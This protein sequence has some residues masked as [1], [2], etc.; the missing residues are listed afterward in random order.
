MGILLGPG[1][2]SSALPLPSSPGFTEYDAIQNIFSGQVGVNFETLE[3]VG[4]YC[5]GLPLSL[6]G[7]LQTLTF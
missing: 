1:A 7:H 5:T 4:H 3:A 6:A 2:E